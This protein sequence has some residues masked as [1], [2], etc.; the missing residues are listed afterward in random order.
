[1]AIEVNSIFEREEK[2]SGTHWMTIVEKKDDM[3]SD[4]EFVRK[5]YAL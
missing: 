4:D 2:E 3:G 1:M 5:K